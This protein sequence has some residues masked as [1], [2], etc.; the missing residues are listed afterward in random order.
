MNLLATV[1][2]LSPKIGTLSKYLF[3]FCT[4]RDVPFLCYKYCLYFGWGVLIF[5]IRILFYIILLHQQLFQLFCFYFYLYFYFYFLGVDYLTQKFDSMEVSFFDGNNF[6][7][8]T[9]EFFE[10]YLW[11]Q[12]F[13]KFWFKSKIR[14][15]CVFWYQL[16]ICWFLF[17]NINDVLILIYW[18]Q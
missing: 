4:W 1:R 14:E 9:I 6:T 5:A 13:L 2:T 16:L 10:W 15:I 17:L 12:L 18:Y 3:S 7:N 11:F 8:F